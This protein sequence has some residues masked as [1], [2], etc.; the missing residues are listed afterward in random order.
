MTIGVIA[1]NSARPRK[2]MMVVMK[3]RMVDRLLLLV[4]KVVIELTD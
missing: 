3:E 4:L 2:V 1:K